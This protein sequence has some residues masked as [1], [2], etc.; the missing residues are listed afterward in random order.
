MYTP[1]CVTFRSRHTKIVKDYICKY[2]LLSLPKKKCF[3]KNVQS[4][5]FV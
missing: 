4:C 1:L 5:T 2:I 3:K